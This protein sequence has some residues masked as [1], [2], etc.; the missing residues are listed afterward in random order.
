MNRILLYL[1]V[2]I[3][4][5]VKA[6]E[7]VNWVPDEFVLSGFTYSRL[8]K[9][10]SILNRV[11]QTKM[12]KP[13]SI[14]PKVE[15]EDL[16]SFDLEGW[17]KPVSKQ[18]S[19]DYRNSFGQIE[20]NY[21]YIFTFIPGGE[22]QGSGKYIEALFVYARSIDIAFGLKFSSHSKVLSVSNIGTKENPVV[23]MLVKVEYSI[24]NG[25][26]TT[27]KSDIFYLTGRGEIIKMSPEIEPYIG[28]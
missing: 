17:M 16:S 12:F 18:F 28:Q 6:A 24:W 22:Y 13:V 25:L 27:N 4:L 14:L 21:K 7:Q 20:A 26:K 10:N 2:V 15:G 3:S 8:V 19:A 9:K 1:M 11:K 23:S 5:E